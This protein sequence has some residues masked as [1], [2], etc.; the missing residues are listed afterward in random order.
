MNATRWQKSTFSGGGVGNDCVELGST[1]TH[2][3]LRESEDPATELLTAP[4]T[5]AGLLRALRAG[6]PLSPRP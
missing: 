1:G 5:L 3:R 6:G 2:I 4:E